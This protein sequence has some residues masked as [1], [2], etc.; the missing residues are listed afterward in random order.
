MEDKRQHKK[1]NRL[2]DLLSKFFISLLGM[3]FVL[4]LS[5]F[6]KNAIFD[7]SPPEKENQPRTKIIDYRSSNDSQAVSRTETLSLLKPVANNLGIENKNN[8]VP[9]TIKF[10]RFNPS[11]DHDKERNKDNLS[12]KTEIIVEGGKKNDIFLIG[13]YD[14]ME[15]GNF[16]QSQKI[17]IKTSEE[18]EQNSVNITLDLPVAT[19]KQSIQLPILL[20][21]AIVNSYSNNPNH[22]LNKNGILNIY[23]QPKNEKAAFIS[24]IIKRTKEPITISGAK[25]KGQWLEKEFATIPASILKLLMSAKK[26][27]YTKKLTLIAA[28]L[29]THFGYQTGKE[30]V[31]RE[32]GKTWNSLLSE[33][34]TINKK[35]FAD[36][37]VLSTFAYI[38]LK[39]LQLDPIFIVGYF[40]FEKNPQE[41]E[42][43]QLHATLYLRNADTGLMFESTIFTKSANSEK[44]NAKNY[45]TKTSR[46]DLETNYFLPPQGL[47]KQFQKGNEANSEIRLNQIWIKIKNSKEVSKKQKKITSKFLYQ[48]ILITMILSLSALGILLY[49]K[50]RN[51]R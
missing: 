20:K 39:F 23:P 31:S 24:Y 37:D 2:F 26:Y 29:N 11:G 44:N 40:N 35:L 10:P 25:E 1:E 47:W 28:I 42:A 33:K 8:F 15:N 48:A 17:N 21:G 3:L 36:C 49:K 32:T 30:D 41:L 13:I 51:K 27:S 16:S 46:K 12:K 19:K 5:F 22:S 38:Y 9:A 50:G 43:G 18:F 4:M 7:S 14:Q 45:S 6:V 34:I